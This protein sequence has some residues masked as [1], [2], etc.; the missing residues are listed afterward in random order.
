MHKNNYKIP[1]DREILEQ[2]EKFKADPIQ[3]AHKCVQKPILYDSQ[4]AF[5]EAVSKKTDFLLKTKV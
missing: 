3:I 5:I 4:K 2:Y 1:S